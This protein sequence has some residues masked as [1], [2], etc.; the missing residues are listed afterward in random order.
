MSVTRS[1]L[2][3][4]SLSSSTTGSRVARSVYGGA[5]GRNV[6]VST[7]NGYGFDLGGLGGDSSSFV[8]GSS[9][10]GTMQN[11]NDRLAVYLQKVRSLESANSQ[12]EIQ[13]RQWYDKQTPTVN[14][15]SKYDVIIADL[16]AK[17]T[18]ISPLP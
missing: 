3:S 10:K 18:P 2:S 5:G 15:Y 9:E 17:V 14:D 6:Q 8:L 1:G 4:F 12:L 13:I 11:L 16:R 7:S